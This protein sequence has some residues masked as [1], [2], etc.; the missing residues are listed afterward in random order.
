M[1]LHLDLVA[2]GPWLRDPKKLRIPEAKPAEAHILS[3]RMNQMVWPTL[4][5]LEYDIDIACRDL[6][7][8]QNYA[9]D[10]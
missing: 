8:Q 6:P 2:W 9:I 3:G 10:R 7:K 1:F 4:L 5:K